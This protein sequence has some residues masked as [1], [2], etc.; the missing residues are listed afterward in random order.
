[1]RFKNIYLLSFIAVILLACTH[2]PNRQK[3]G[4]AF[5]GLIGAIAGSKIGDGTGKTAAILS[6]T[7]LGSFFGNKLG[8]S[9]DIADRIQI[10][11]AQKSAYNRPIRRVV[12]WSNHQNDHYG[13]NGANKRY[14]REFQQIIA[15]EGQPYENVCE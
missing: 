4:N 12:N 3:A 15:V 13:S 9:L 11:K 7:T 5:G 6:G 14:C 10:K 8:K 1:M 2:T